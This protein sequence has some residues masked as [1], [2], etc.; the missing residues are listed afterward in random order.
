MG[1]TLSSTS[2]EEHLVGHQTKLYTHKT[3]ATILKIAEQLKTHQHLRLLNIPWNNF[4]DEAVQLLSNALEFNT[5]LE[6]LDVSSNG[7]GPAGAAFTSVSLCRNSTL[8]SL[9]LGDNA[10]GDDGVTALALHVLQRN[11]T[12]E[13]LN[14]HSNAIGDR[15]LSALAST[16]KSTSTLRHLDLSR[17]LITIEGAAALA[18]AF[19]ANRQRGYP[20]LETLK[21][22]S[23]ALPLWDLAGSGK[24]KY[25]S[26][27]LKAVGLRPVD[28]VVIGM[29]IGVNT[30]CTSLDLSNNE[31]TGGGI[32]Q[33]GIRLLAQALQRNTTLTSLD[34]SKNGIGPDA[35]L[36]FAQ[37]C[38]HNKSLRQL[39][40]RRNFLRIQ[41]YMGRGMRPVAPKAAVETP[42]T[43][44]RTGSRAGSSRSGSRQKQARNYVPPPTE[45][46]ADTLDYR[47]IRFDPAEH[48]I[49]RELFRRNS[50][51]TVLNGIACEAEWPDLDFATRHLYPYEVVVIARKIFM[52]PA[53]A[54]VDFAD[55]ALSAVSVA[56]LAGAIA[57]H[58]TLTRLDLS[59]N[60]AS[61][62]GANA[63]ARMLRANTVLQS[64]CLSHN[65]IGDVGLAPILAVL[66]APPR[67][68]G[69]DDDDDDD[70][71]DDAVLRAAI[72]A[73]QRAALGNAAH[74]K[75][76][77]APK[78]NKTLM[79][80][81][82]AGNR[83]SAR[84]V[85]A[86]GTM[87]CNN[88]TLTDVDIRWNYAR[89]D[90][91]NALLYACATKGCA[92]RTLDLVANE[93]D[94]QG[95]VVLAASLHR[96]VALRTLK[97]D[98][99]Q[100]RFN[101]WSLGLTGVRALSSLLLHNA[102]LTELS[103]NH[104]NVG[105]AGGILLAHALRHNASLKMLSLRGSFG[106]DFDPAADDSPYDD[107]DPWTVTVGANGYPV[108]Q[109]QPETSAMP[110][111]VSGARPTSAQVFFVAKCS[112]KL[113]TKEKGNI[114]FGSGVSASAII[115]S[116]GRSHRLAR[117]RIMKETTSDVQRWNREHSR[118]VR[119]ER[120]MRV[121]RHASGTARH[122]AEWSAELISAL[123]DDMDEAR[124]MGADYLKQFAIADAEK[125]AAEEAAEEAE[126]EDEKGV[127]E[128]EVVSPRWGKVRGA[129]KI[130]AVRKALLDGKTLDSALDGD[131][132]ALM[133]LLMNAGEREEEAAAKK[134]EKKEAEAEAAKKKPEGRAGKTQV[135]QEERGG[136]LGVGGAA[137][138]VAPLVTDHP[139]GA[140]A[141]A[142]VGGGWDDV[143]G[144]DPIPETFSIDQEEL[145]KKFGAV[146]K[147]AA[148]ELD[149]RIVHSK[150]EMRLQLHAVNVISKLLHDEI[151]LYLGIGCALEPTMLLE[152]YGFG[153][154][155]AG[156]DAL[157][158]ALQC[159]NHTAITTIDLARNAIGDV[160]ATALA[161]AVTENPVLWRQLLHVDVSHN[162]LSEESVTKLV[163]ALGREKVEGTC[164]LILTGNQCA[165]DPAARMRLLNMSKS[166]LIIS[167]HEM[168]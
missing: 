71:D 72:V 166:G 132:A 78:H 6:D 134:K 136:D 124:L 165:N 151:M 113:A 82:L 81:E 157:A 20:G 163:V 129:M 68:A 17:N 145:A 4:D 105:S 90:Q 89:I 32:A 140:G 126:E 107:C 35:A 10:I 73:R 18:R 86:I 84:G 153:I 40:I 37:A 147:K 3:N 143:D 162:A 33:T 96:N 50:S 41:E 31:L 16:L 141:G 28:A 88:R 156:V 128:A 15:G 92:L 13:V 66:T 102:S 11:T 80:L 125:A 46:L 123:P 121:A 59:Y 131:D 155:S 19:V 91:R 42:R 45:E 146:D 64:L 61:V 55:C 116:I 104:A 138:V 144:Q 74:A 158:H 118:K 110:E 38:C 26:M 69:A 111:R 101:G 149:K 70:D 142:N 53:L 167:F 87:L 77:V 159:N 95:C 62:L 98:R 83:I 137:L 164:Y 100:P 43:G 115:S 75:I 5:V 160:G 21:L 8:R 161:H 76:V 36:W 148:A 44:S 108:D 30:V 106:S 85:S 94:T 34:V 79:Q 49:L 168:F 114:K 97:L 135:V 54:E 117:A 7:I 109:L 127:K 12:L 133:M 58:P 63:L 60:H 119:Y 1:S 51:V 23:F 24:V 103:F 99:L 56:T 65:S 57:K 150:K 152:T 22:A 47:D 122:A 154:G 52:A 25:E 48:V 112:E 2:T 14:L 39:R 9:N 29:L 27:E 120:C 130:D 139:A 67:R 93:L